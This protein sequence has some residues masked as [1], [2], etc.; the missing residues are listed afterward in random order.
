MR[1]DQDT[2]EMLQDPKFYLENFCKIKG[3]TPGLIPFILNEAQK[4]FLNTVRKSSRA[5]VLKARQVG[6]CLDENTKVL[7]SDF[8]WVRISEVRPGDI[9]VGVDEFGIGVTKNGNTNQRKMR[10]T[11]VEAT[12]TFREETLKLT[13]ENGVEII[14]TGEHRLL[15]KK[16]G[17]V[18]PEWKTVSSLKVGNVLR[19]VSKTW[20]DPTNEDSWFGGMIDGEGH[21][22]LPSRSGVALG[23]SQVDGPVWERLLEYVK[24]RGYNFRIEVDKRSAGESSKLGSKDVNKVVI[25]RIDDVFKAMGL[26]RPARFLPRGGDWW[27]GK[28]LPGGKIRHV[29]WQKI[30]KIE[31]AGVRN[32]VDLQ[33]STKTFIAEGFVSHNSTL[34]SGYLYHRTITSPGMNTAL[35][36]YNADLTTELLDKVKTFYRTTAPELRPKIQY[37]SKY[38]I[39]FP[40]LDSKI[41]VLPSSENVGRGYTLHNVLCV[42]G[43]TIVY[44]KNGAHKKVSDVKSGDVI[45]NGNGGFSPVKMVVK[46]ENKESLLALDVVGAPDNLKITRDHEVFVRDDITRKGKW[47][48][49]EDIVPGMRIGIPYYQCRNRVKSVDLDEF[50]TYNHRGLSAK[51]LGSVPT[52]GELG[53]L[54]GWY[55][56]EGTAGGNR[57][58]FS[59]H[60]DEID[61]I[62]DVVDGALGHVG[63][64]PTIQTRG[65]GA[66]VTY[67]NASLAKWFVEKFGH[68][69]ANKIIPDFVWYWGWNFCKGLIFGLFEGDGCFTDVRK[70]HLVTTSSSIANQVRRM[71][72]SLRLGLPS[73]RQSESSRYGKVGKNRWDVVLSGPGNYKFRR[74][75]G[76]PLPEYVDKRNQW[77]IINTPWANLGQ[78]TW[79]RGKTHYWAK[80]RS[81]T[82]VDAEKFVYDIVLPN[83][84]HSFLTSAG[85]VSNCTELAFWDKPEEK[86]LAI[87]NAV[88]SSGKIIIESTPNGIGNLFHRMWA[89]ENDYA[90]K[91][92]GWWWHYS[93]DEIDIIRRRVNDPR[94]FAQEY[95]LEFLSTGRNVFDIQVLKR[96]ME[97]VFRVGDV[98]KD[99]DGKDFTVYEHDTGIRIYREPRPGRVYVCGV[100]VAEGVSGGDSST[101]CILDRESGEEVAFFKGFLPP[102]KY[103]ERLNRWGRMYNNALMIVEINNHG[104]TTVTGLKNLMYPQMYFRQAKFDAV[105]NGQ[106]DRLGWKTTKVTRPLLIDDLNEVLRGES[107]TLH[108]KETLDEMVTFIYDDGA[109]MVPQSGFHDDCIFATGIAV[110]GFKVIHTRPLDQIDYQ[111][112]L[113]KSHSY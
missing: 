30:I 101:A 2:L 26:A 63:L 5:I 19:Y 6:F 112:Y 40:T 22:A 1:V 103:A 53:R 15:S 3:K 107:I 17:G 10:R 59:V 67:H 65:N 82:E 73:L 37:N 21:L 48:A 35:I 62:K 76:L 46:R 96:A 52:N 72:V 79:L 93:E 27:E 94:K 13:L 44:G 61:T 113:P 11:V 57:V 108:T 90:K 109:N 23:V 34:V 28:S 81:V 98:V 58:T 86:M 56:A 71:M 91:A 50:F 95:E 104:L 87:E 29:A 8:K 106:G 47:V 85:V 42:S 7:R 43:D 45:I 51:S 60:V 66:T 111:E 55:L 74:E 64:I 68:G 31:Y 77:R 100:D 69:A 83:D 102:D 33:T 84:P 32:V 4:D 39:S 14:A 12:R 9:L 80:V 41:L 110:Q 99:H 97:N 24:T 36:G 25:S 105:A 89:A 18:E 88:P 20:G 92:Y 38:E 75:F 54:V 49:G 16:N 70:V 78:K